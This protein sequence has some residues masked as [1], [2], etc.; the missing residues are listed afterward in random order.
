MNNIGY[1]E[2]YILI[3]KIDAYRAKPSLRSIFRDLYCRY[4]PVEYLINK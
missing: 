1:G 2:F 3:L 4:Y